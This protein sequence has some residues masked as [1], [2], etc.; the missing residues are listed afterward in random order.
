MASWSS[1]TRRLR[2]DRH[3][4]SDESFKGVARNRRPRTVVEL[5]STEP[6]TSVGG[7]PEANEAAIGV[8]GPAYR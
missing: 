1:S 3:Y 5:G 2:V 4:A 7:K 6:G 8:T